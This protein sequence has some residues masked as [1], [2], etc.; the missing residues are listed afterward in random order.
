MSPRSRSQKQIVCLDSAV[1]TLSNVSRRCARAAEEGGL[2]IKASHARILDKGMLACFSYG[3][4]SE[5][6][7]AY[8]DDSVGVREEMAGAGGIWSCLLGG[9]GC[10]SAPGLK[11]FLLRLRKL[12]DAG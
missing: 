3:Q 12:L 2:Q 1:W 4:L 9:L 5:Q 6:R 10:G 7:T 11:A 8:N